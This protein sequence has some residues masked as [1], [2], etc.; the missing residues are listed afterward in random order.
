MC[1][2]QWRCSVL[3]VARAVAPPTTVLPA[4]T[5]SVCPC[6]RVPC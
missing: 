6:L 1:V 3:A 4:A 5:L 2:G